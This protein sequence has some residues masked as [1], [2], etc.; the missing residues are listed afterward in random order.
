M[1]HSLYIELTL[2]QWFVI[3]E[4]TWIGESKIHWPFLCSHIV[5][6][7][8]VGIFSLTMSTLK[9][10]FTM[11]LHNMIKHNPRNIINYVFYLFHGA[12]EYI[13]LKNIH[14]MC[15]EKCKYIPKT[16]ELFLTFTKFIISISRA[17]PHILNHVCEPC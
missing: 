3:L 6:F 12:L 16:F 8:S 13:C 4:C 11:F 9:K 15:I 1:H 2:F 17:I 14:V 10:Q 7:S 5:L